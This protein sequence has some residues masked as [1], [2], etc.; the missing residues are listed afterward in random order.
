VSSPGRTPRVSNL[1]FGLIAAV[2]LGILVYL[3]FSRSLPFGGDEYQV[4]ATFENAA[5]L[6]SNSPVRIAGVNVGEVTGLERDGDAAKVT[7]TVSDE[8]RPI[9][10]DATVKIRPRLF[11]EG[12][13]FLDLRPGSPSA[14]ELPDGGSIPITST[15]VAVQFDEILTALQQPQRRSL[16]DLFDG[17]GTGLNRRPT[18]A[19]DADQDPDVRGES[20]AKAIHDSFQNGERA[21]EGTAQVT[22][23][24][25]GTEPRDL[26]RLIAG[27]RQVFRGLARSQTQLRDLVTNLNV[28]A[29]A[30]AT[31][32]AKLSETVAE[33]A[34]TLE[35]ARPALIELNR[36]F[37]PLREFARAL[38]PGIAQLPATIDVATPWL[39]Q[40]KPL[41]ADSELG[42]IAGFLRIATPNLAVSIRDAGGLGTELGRTG[43]CLS[44]PLVPALSAVF[45]RSDDPFKT[46]VE[47]YKEFFY[48][49]V[50]QSGE[51]QNFDG[52]GQYARVQAGGGP[53][54]VEA[55]NPNGGFENT[56]VFGQTIE[57]PLGIQPVIPSSPPP[58]REDIQC[59]TNDP[60]NINGPAAAV[61]SPSPAAIP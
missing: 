1:R 56:E 39:A 14:D 19:E 13:F 54:R 28:T 24:L 3:A 23:A 2:V 41:L 15:S 18:P 34:P 10:E 27:S 8:G 4:T 26:S 22:Q 59:H 33:L 50:Q 31:E 43:R 12:N 46:G 20:A 17:L 38:E 7:F 21:L 44:D 48:G 25:Q 29:G 51:S 60:P 16:Q 35:Q 42:G 47:N 53:V 40:A 30:F 57:A 49:L 32:S 55:A 58:I 37:P 45:D 5:T 9:R 61:G 11:L 52:N 6:R 36:L